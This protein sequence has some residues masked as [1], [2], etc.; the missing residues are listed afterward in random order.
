[1]AFHVTTQFGATE[2]NVS[3]ERMARIL[4]TIDPDDEEHVDVSLTHES[5]WCIGV[6]ASGLVVFEN[7]EVGDPRHIYL[8]SPGEAL[9]LWKHLSRG[10]LA[11]LEVLPWLPGYG[12]P[13][14][15]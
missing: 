4:A 15:G 3:P 13:A 1:M 2:R 14:A 10:E 7:L 6:F 8:A 11:Q 5:E 9:P 12:S